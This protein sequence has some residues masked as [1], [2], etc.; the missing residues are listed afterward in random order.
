MDGTGAVASFGDTMKRLNI[1]DMTG[2]AL[3]VQTSAT[4]ETSKLESKRA[5]A[6]NKS[7][8]LLQKVLKVKD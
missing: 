4:L 1:I 7:N 2:K 5:L 6:R 8:L 3:Q